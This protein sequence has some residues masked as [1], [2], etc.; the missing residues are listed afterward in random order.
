MSFR[1]HGC[2][3]LVVDDEDL[4]RD[5]FI[6]S[7]QHKGY[8]VRGACNGQEGAELF[9][10][11]QESIGLLLTDLTMPHKGGIELIREV[12]AVKPEL[13]ILL[14]SGNHQEW[15]ED[16]DGVTCIAKPFTFQT[17]VAEVEKLEAQLHDAGGDEPS[18]A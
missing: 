12:K 7:L 1:K 11:E 16:L 18:R 13:P 4:L 10:R 8:V 2:T 9:Q 15:S 14:M 6:M 17:L 3:I 5:F